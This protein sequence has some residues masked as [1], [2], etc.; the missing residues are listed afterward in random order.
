M[1]QKKVYIVTV[2]SKFTRMVLTFEGILAVDDDQAKD[3]A[4]D[5][6]KYPEAWEADRAKAYQQ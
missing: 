4:L 3:A 5:I 1:A 2:K 6:L